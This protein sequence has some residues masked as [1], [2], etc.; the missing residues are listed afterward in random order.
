MTHP[1]VSIASSRTENHHQPHQHYVSWRYGVLW[2]H[3]D[4]TLARVD[5]SLP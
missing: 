3:G 2:R 4:I 1:L 5:T